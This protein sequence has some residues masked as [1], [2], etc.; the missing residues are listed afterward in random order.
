MF[1]NEKKYLPLVYVQF[2]STFLI[3]DSCDLSLLQRLAGAGLV[4]LGRAGLCVGGLEV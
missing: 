2:Y 1:E 4:G 3:P